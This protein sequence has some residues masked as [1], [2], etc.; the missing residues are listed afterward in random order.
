MSV[1]DTWPK[2][3]RPSTT[4]ST[5]HTLPCGRSG[6]S[7]TRGP[8]SLTSRTQRLRCPTLCHAQKCRSA[9]HSEFD[10]PNKIHQNNPFWR[11]S[12]IQFRQINF[13]NNAF[14]PSPHLCRFVFFSFPSLPLMISN[15]NHSKLIFKP[16]GTFAL[17]QTSLRCWILNPDSSPIS[18][19][20]PSFIYQTRIRFENGSDLLSPT[21]PFRRRNRGAQIPTKPCCWTV[22]TNNEVRLRSWK[23]QP[24]H[25][26]FSLV[27]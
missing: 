18:N 25:S 13:R 9:K 19:S 22:H 3:L 2:I 12:I 7:W 17:P 14:F 1:D 10:P 5:W 24:P 21:Q 6:A 26:M 27:F 11:K 23:V 4:M 16:L 15:L 20:S 8:V